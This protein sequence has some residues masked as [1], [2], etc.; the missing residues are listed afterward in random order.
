MSKKSDAGNQNSFN[1]SL[2]LVMKSGKF[3]LGYRETLRTLRS[4]KSK[5]VVVSNNCPTVRQ[6]EIEY[7][8]ILSKTPVHRFE[9]GNTE[10][11]TACGRYFQVSMLTILESGDSDILRLCTN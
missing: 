6:S 7:Y 2:K 10:L 9:G 1:A 4:G 3:K 5:L 11:G 8:A